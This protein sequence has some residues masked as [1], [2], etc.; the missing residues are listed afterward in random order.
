VADAAL[1]T[2]ALTD[3]QPGEFFLADANCGLSVE[4]ALRML[5]LFPV[6]ETSSWKAHGPHGAKVLFFAAEQMC[7]LSSMNWQR[8]LAPSYSSSQMTELEE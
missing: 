4:N 8:T 5:R 1:I 7:L 3:R 6:G 2:A